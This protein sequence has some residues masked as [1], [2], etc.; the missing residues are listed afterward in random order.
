MSPYG[1]LVMAGNVWEW[2]ADRHSRTYYLNS[3]LENPPGPDTGF[4]R[5]LRGGGME[6]ARYV[7]PVHAPEPRRAHNQPLLCR[8][9]LRGF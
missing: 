1:A 7:C 5:V 3:P 9:S 8:F 6:L 4:F 2:V